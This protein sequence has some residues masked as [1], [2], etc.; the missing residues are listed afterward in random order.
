MHKYTLILGL[1]FISFL[2][3]AQ[4]IKLDTTY[5]K[6]TELVE[7]NEDFN[8]F[9]VCEVDKKGRNIG[10]CTKFNRQNSPVEISNYKKGVLH[11]AY[12]RFFASGETL[13]EGEYLNGQREGNWISY[14]KE[15]TPLN[16][17]IYEKGNEM[18][19]RA[20]DLVSQATGQEPMFI[21][22]EEQPQFPGGPQAWMQFLANNL[23][24]P[25]EAK[26]RNIKGP[27]YVKFLVSKEGFI[28]NPKILD[29]PS[30]ILS[31]EALRVIR[32][33]PKWIPKKV[34]G[35]PMDGYMEFRINF[36]F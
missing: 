9:Q 1:L 23:V 17:E 16:I 3:S 2:A 26:E 35:E 6:G 4:K 34:S 20:L 31:T 28:L 11:G 10:V 30:P 12:K 14:D 25:K 8:L 18:L 36:S 33:S 24:Y 22:V 32:L 15:G 13:L 7:I 19:S 21:V 29:S 27:V 5:F